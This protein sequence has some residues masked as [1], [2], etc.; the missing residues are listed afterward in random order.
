MTIKDNQQVALHPSCGLDSQPEWV[1]FNEFV[2]TKR[3]YIRTVSDI[4]PEW[5][6]EMAPAYFDL[7]TFADGE[8]K[9]ALQ[10]AL[11]KTV[12]GGTPIASNKGSRVGTPAG[13]D[14]E[15]EKKRRKKG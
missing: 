12:K 14:G 4:K 3:P 13:G 10:R 1:V 8:T 11:N 7:S 9:R 15:R 6:M 2:L 5:L